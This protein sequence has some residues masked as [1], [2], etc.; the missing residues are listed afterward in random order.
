MM[1]WIKKAKQQSN[2]QS[3]TTDS[4]T[5]DEEGSERYIN[6]VNETNETDY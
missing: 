1:K 4:D 6:V 2:I 5:E 3:Y